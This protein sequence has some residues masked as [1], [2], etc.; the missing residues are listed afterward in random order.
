MKM[1]WLNKKT[2][3]SV[4]IPKLPELPKLPDL[5][6]FDEEKSED[7]SMENG[8]IIPQLKFSGKNSK[9]P[10]LPSFPS[11]SFGES[12]SQNT[13]KEAI[14][15]K[16]EDEKEANEFEENSTRFQE[17]QRMQPTLSRIKTQNIKEVEKI[18]KKTEPIFIRLD[19]F[20]ESVKLFEKI[21]E[22]VTEMSNMLNDIKKIKEE[23][24]KELEY[25]E[26]ELKEIKEKISKVDRDIFSMIE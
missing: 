7:L 8:E 24:E 19:K 1:G 17:P 18:I 15:G 13:I 16:K 3:E 5:P 6:S 4:E 25:W 14:A 20:E 21:K 11:T 26:Q 2:G 9:L 22:E 12:L 10:S 23:E